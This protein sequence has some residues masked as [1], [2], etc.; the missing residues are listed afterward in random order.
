MLFLYCP[1]Y[2]EE[3]PKAEEAAPAVAAEPHG[4]APS[5]VVEP[6]VTLLPNPSNVTLVPSPLAAVPLPPAGG[7]TVLTGVCTKLKS[8]A[9][10]GS[11]L[12]GRVGS[13][14]GGGVL[15]Q[16]FCQPTCPCVLLLLSCCRL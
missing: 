1:R 6:N 14:G 2:D 5:E 3:P 4:E 12:F 13:R 9:C 8:T 10:V 7:A 16:F 15:A 11:C